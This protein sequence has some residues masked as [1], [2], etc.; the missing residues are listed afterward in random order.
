LNDLESNVFPLPVT[1]SPDYEVLAAPGLTLQG[2][3]PIRNKQFLHSGI[4]VKTGPQN[5]ILLLIQSNLGIEL[6]GTKEKLPK[7]PRILH[8]QGKIH[9]KYISKDHKISSTSPWHLRYH[10]LRY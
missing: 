2:S 9:K 4:Q 10:C 7:Y 5:P 6:D 8:I 3:L 1:I